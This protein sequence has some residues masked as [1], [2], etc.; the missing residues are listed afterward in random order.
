MSSYRDAIERYMDEGL[1]RHAAEIEAALD[2]IGQQPK[3]RSYLWMSP[4]DPAYPFDDDD[5]TTNQLT[6]DTRL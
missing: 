4:R 1:R 2:D 6:G 5:T 3:R